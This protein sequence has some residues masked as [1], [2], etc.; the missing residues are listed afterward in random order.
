MPKRT[1]KAETTATK[2]VA[3]VAKATRRP[4]AAKAEPVAPAPTQEEIALRAYEIHQSGTGGDALE[5][6]LRAERELVAV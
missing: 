2:R 5:H 4:R 1:T 6:W 3:R